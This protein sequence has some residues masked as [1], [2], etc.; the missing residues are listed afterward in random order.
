[1]SWDI[2]FISEQD[3]T[4]H[5]RATI[6]KYGEK[7]E[8]V[9]L[10]RFNKNIVDPIKLI[11]DK[12]VYRS[13]WEETIGNEIFRQRDKSNNNDIGYFHQRI[14]QYIKNC[15]VPLNG[16][17]G[18]WDVIYTDPDGITLPDGAVVHTVYVEMKNK[19]NT[20]NSTSASK[21]FIKMQNQLLK[22]DD[23]ACFLVEAIAKKSQ[24]VKWENTVDGKTVGHRFIRRVSIDQFYALVT[25][26]KDAFYRLCIHLPEVIQRVVDL[27]GNDLV[28]HD[29]VVEELIKASE[30]SG[31]ESRDL[32]ILMS[33]YMM[34]FEG[35]Y[36]FEK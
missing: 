36:G 32:A 22:D 10:K 4:D 23:C 18:G 14:F 27:E 1:M 17:E 5:V 31:I 15:R 19:H 25:G 2:T 8:S 21:T 24:N 28:P 7:L 3:F 34:G 6:Q 11:F 13:S 20:M 16:A 35:Y 29:T 12:T 33:I 30:N 9:D 26:Q